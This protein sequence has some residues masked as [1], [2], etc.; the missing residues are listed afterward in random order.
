EQAQELFKP[1]LIDRNTSAEILE[2]HLQQ[3]NPF[4]FI[5]IGD[6]EARFLASVGLTEGE[7]ATIDRKLYLCGIDIEDKPD[8]GE[9]A[10]V[11]RKAALVGVQQPGSSPDMWWAATLD[12]LRK[13]RLLGEK[14]FLE[15]HA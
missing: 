13:W 12:G 9:F 3:G 14:S 10:E 1:H 15:I 4:S 2:S 7:Q 11:I 5:R 6:V 8:P